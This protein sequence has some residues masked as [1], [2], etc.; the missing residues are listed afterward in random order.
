MAA[1][2]GKKGI[3]AHVTVENAGKTILPEKLNNFETKKY[4]KNLHDSSKM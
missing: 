3:S 1:V 4:L 2:T